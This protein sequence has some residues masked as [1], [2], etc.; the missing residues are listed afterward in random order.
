M[1]PLDCES[2]DERYSL[3]IVYKWIASLTLQGLFCKDELAE[4]QDSKTISKP[5]YSGSPSI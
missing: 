5:I 2:Q 4:M 3:K 1:I